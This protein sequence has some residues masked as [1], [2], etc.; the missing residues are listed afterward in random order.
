MRPQATQ[1]QKTTSGRSKS[2]AELKKGDRVRGDVFMIETANFK[3]TRDGK[4]FV[5][6]TLRD[7]TASVRAIRWE[8]SRDLYA[9]ISN[10][11]FLRLDGR[12]EEFQQNLQII[13]D[14]LDVVDPHEV[15]FDEF[16]PVSV[17]DPLEM[18]RELLE[19][20]AT[21]KQD[22]I[23]RLLVAFVEDPE[24]REGLLRCPA[25]KT[26]HHAYVGGL[27]EHIL[28]LVNAAKLVTKNYPR[29]DRDV[30]VAAAVLHDI[31][32]IRELTFT[33][34]FG[35]SDVGQLVGHVGLA[36]QMLQEKIAK[37]ESFPEPMRIHLE[38]II[39]SHHGQLEHG[40]LKVPMTAEAIAFHFLDNLDSKMAM[41]EDMSNE[42][43]AGSGTR[44]GSGQWTEFKPA[45]S[46]R[47][48]FPGD[49]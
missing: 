31:G 32:K 33:S 4:F 41:I 22:D 30:L 24:I 3:Q 9:S 7:K 18:E 43:A 10:A 26:L 35:Y 13:V 17:R 46:R 28:S 2:V 49:V 25:G 1:Q 5:Q 47:V 42:I 14:R 23:R 48:F 34:A 20:I 44:P 40:A 37:L 11:Q 36:L 27:L 8:A 15:K 6:M 21:V 45:L 16:L 29:L 19:H 39:A 12:V 38:H